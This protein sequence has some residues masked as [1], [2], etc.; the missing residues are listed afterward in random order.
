M[1][2]KIAYW[3]KHQELDKFNY[4]I[5]FTSFIGQLS[6]CIAV[7]IGTLAII[8]AIDELDAWGQIILIVIV[9]G[10]FLIWIKKKV[11]KPNQTKLKDHNRSFRIREAM[12][13]TWYQQLEVDTD[14]LD[15]QYEEIKTK[16]NPEILENKHLEEIAKKV[17]LKSQKKGKNQK[18]PSP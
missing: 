18:S 4:N 10:A 8:L 1:D 13:R 14:L 5:S 2:K 9:G 3:T 6:M 17:I 16:S 15:K 12:L 7:L 11:I